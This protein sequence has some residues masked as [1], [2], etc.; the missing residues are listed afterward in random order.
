MDFVNSVPRLNMD[1]KTN[2]KT[3]MINKLMPIAFY[4]WS[5]AYSYLERIRSEAVWSEDA[6][7]WTLPDLAT[8]PIKL[9]P[10]AG[11]KCF[12]SVSNMAIF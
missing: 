1:V 7:T 6:K 11:I 5:V 2:L 12:N 4:Q 10:A 3:T 9:P 8:V